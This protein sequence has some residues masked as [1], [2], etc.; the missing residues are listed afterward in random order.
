M[1]PKEQASLRVQAYLYHNKKRLEVVSVD[2]IVWE[3]RMFVPEAS[4]LLDS[5]L[6][7]TV[8]IWRSLNGPLYPLPIPA[9]PTAGESKLIE[10]VKKG[11]TTVIEGV[12][13][14]HGAGKVN[15][16]IT[17]LTA[18][19]KKGDAR[20]AA[21]V[22]WGGTLGVEAEAGN[23]HL[24]GELSSDRWE[25][26][27]SYPEDTAIPDLSKLGKVFGEGEGAMRKI[28]SATS[29]FRDLNDASRVKDA[30]KPHMQPVKDAVEAVKGIAKAPAKGGVSVGISVGSPEPLPGETGI[31]RGVQGQITLTLRF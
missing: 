21:G 17:G 22:S 26:K 6:R 12:D 14:K 28:I 4:R 13:I 2:L 15:I 11:V 27:L 29:S 5:E 24:S 7:A 18:E 9:P 10:A 20:L 23:F 1:D 16:S 8:A 30:I 25:L 19:L 31:P 3:V